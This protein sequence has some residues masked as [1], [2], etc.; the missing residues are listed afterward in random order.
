[1][2]CRGQADTSGKMLAFRDAYGRLAELRALLPSSV[3]MTAL[4]ATATAEDRQT[5]VTSLGM[6]NIAFVT[7][8]PDRPNIR[9]SYIEVEEN[10]ET[11]FEWLIQHL[12]GL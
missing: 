8:S 5:I 3:P 2:F 12:K 4:T 1:M 6:S 9:Y 10:E 7:A 11:T